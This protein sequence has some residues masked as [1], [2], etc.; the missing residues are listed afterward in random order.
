[1]GLKEI[2]LGLEDK[3]YALLDKID[4]VVPVY[5]LVDPIDKVAPSFILFLIAIAALAVFFVV[6]PLLPALQ[7]GALVTLAVEDEEGN[8]LQG[9]GVDYTVGENVNTLQ[10]D[11]DGKISFNAPFNSGV[12]VRIA[13]TTIG[14]VEYDGKTGSFSVESEATVSKKIILSKKAPPFVEHT[15]LFQNAAGERVTGKSIK[16]R[17]SCQNPLVTPSPLEVTDDDQDGSI[18]V[19]EPADCGIFQATIIAPDEFKQRSYIL[20]QTAQAIR[21]EGMEAAAKGSLRVKV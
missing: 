1:M 4:E 10:T 11:K 5:K 3:W 19:R 16:V 14:G 21:L 15:V 12:E 8:L 18:V 9:V 7:G 13:D 6:L 2:Y 20:N 17:L